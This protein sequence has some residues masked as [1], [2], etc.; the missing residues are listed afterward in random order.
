MYAAEKKITVSGSD[1]V[2]GLGG[3]KVWLEMKDENQEDAYLSMAYIRYKVF[4]T[5]YVT[6]RQRHNQNKTKNKQQRVPTF[7]NIN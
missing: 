3:N 4:H 6:K 1:K 7:I 2:Y 5:T